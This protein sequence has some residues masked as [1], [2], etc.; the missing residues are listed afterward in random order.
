MNRLSC[1]VGVASVV[2]LAACGGGGSEAP[3]TGGTSADPSAVSA[4]PNTTTTNS[5]TPIA[6]PDPT[7]PA[8]NPPATGTP[9]VAGTSIGCGIANFQADMLGAVN[10]ARASARSCGSDAK[11]AVA[12]IA[13]NNL[14]FNAA[15]A[16]SKDMAERNYFSHDTPEGVN[17]FQRMQN[18]G[19]K[20]GNAGENIAA[21]Q[22]GIASVMDAW[23]K[24]PG[25]CSIIMS[26]DIKDVGASCVKN[27]SGKPYWT[28][29]VAAPQ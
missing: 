17:P 4:L 16:H 20:F 28:M 22:T 1:Y 11:P 19:Y 14:L 3:A 24:S 25:H 26:A 2:L 13:W 9:P 23:L 27:T 12:P 10:K 7:P 5:T 29:G 15:A 8:T 18:A 6:T 21:G